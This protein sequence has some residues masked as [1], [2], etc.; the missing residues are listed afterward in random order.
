MEIAGNLDANDD[1]HDNDDDDDHE[2][3]DLMTVLTASCFII[4]LFTENQLLLLV[5]FW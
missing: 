5:E 1:D 2:Q 3:M 4:T